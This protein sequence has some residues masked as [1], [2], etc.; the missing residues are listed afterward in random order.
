MNYTIYG[1][2]LRGCPDGGS[3]FTSQREFIRACRARMTSEQKSRAMRDARRNTLI[4]GLQYLDADRETY[5]RVQH[6]RAAPT[7]RYLAVNIEQASAAFKAAL[8]RPAGEA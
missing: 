7:R 3:V 6:C 2:I 8:M 1:I 4:A 5:Y